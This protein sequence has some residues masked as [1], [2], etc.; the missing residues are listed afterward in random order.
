MSTGGYMHPEHAEPHTSDGGLQSDPLHSPAD[1]DELVHFSQRGFKYHRVGSLRGDIAVFPERDPDG[2][3]LH[4]G[5]I[6]NA[7]AQKHGGSPFRFLFDN[8]YLFFRVLAKKR[9]NDTDLSGE[10]KNLP[11]AVSGQQHNAPD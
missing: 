9:F 10:V 3:S 11:L 6:I 7:I 5:R 1:K 4:S 8:R 2:G